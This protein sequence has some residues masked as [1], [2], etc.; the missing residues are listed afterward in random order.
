[1]TANVDV[2]GY[3]DLLSSRYTERTRKIE[4]NINNFPH[5]VFYILLAVV[6]P[7]PAI[8]RN[9]ISWAM[10]VRN[11]VN[12][13][14]FPALMASLPFSI[15]RSSR[16]RTRSTACSFSK[17]I[18]VVP[19]ILS[20]CWCL[21]ARFFVEKKSICDEFTFHAAHVNAKIDAINT[22]RIISLICC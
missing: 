3:R 15:A 5:Y 8:S 20:I 9:T 1:M 12:S 19:R 7:R 21:K 10:T 14:K 16:L 2:K 22:N 11:T 4:R 17:A 18:S 6:F 13:N